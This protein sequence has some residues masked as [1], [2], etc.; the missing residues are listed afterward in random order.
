MIVP[1]VSQHLSQIR[2]LCEQYGVERMNLFGSSTNKEK[3]SPETSDV[4]C[5]VKFFNSDQPEITDRHLN[6]AKNL[7]SVLK[8]SVDLVT[9]QSINNPILHAIVERSKI[10]I[11][12]A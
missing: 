2:A 11:Y 5:L 6:L 1:E 10:L 9:E 4:D 7:E 8:R 3:F 12:K